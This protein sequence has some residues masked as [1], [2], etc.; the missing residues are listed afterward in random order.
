MSGYATL[1]E[2]FWFDTPSTTTVQD[3]TVNVPKQLDTTTQLKQ[4]L[5][6]DQDCAVQW[7][8]WSQC[9]L[10]K[11]TNGKD[12]YVQ[13]RSATV[14]K[15][16]RNKGAACPP[17][18]QTQACSSTDCVVGYNNT[19]DAWGDYSNCFL[20]DNPQSQTYN[21]YIKL[22]T[23]TVLTPPVGTGKD[24]G[25]LT[26]TSVCN[27]QNCTYTTLDENTSPWSACYNDNG[28]WKQVRRQYDITDPALYG[29]SCDQ[30]N[31][32][33]TYQNC[34]QQEC[35]V[36]DWGTP[37]A[38][39]RD[40]TTGKYVRMQTRSITQPAL[41]GAA[42]CPALYQTVDCDQKID[43][44][45]N[46]WDDNSWSSCYRKDDGQWYHY[47]TRTVKTIDRYG[48]AP[49]DANMLAEEK[50]CSS[51]DCALTSDWKDYSGTCY[52]KADGLSYKLQYKDFTDGTNGGKMCQEADYIREVLCSVTPTSSVSTATV[53]QVANVQ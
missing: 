46:D 42:D 19:P 27:A 1:R 41:Y 18:V 26:D 50:L 28:T 21:K 34:A 20:D 3:A 6:S 38:C 23:R 12:T 4:F 45:Y 35:K 32:M 40:P 29:G 37:S 9:Y 2:H 31:N 49:C 7:G 5:D 48:G 44:A 10:D 36:S 30:L 11:D 52:N 22:R 39:Y 47:R 51:T 14:T 33:L 8:A 53:Q 13:S 15:Y 17:L 24:C 25:P 16:P 43:C